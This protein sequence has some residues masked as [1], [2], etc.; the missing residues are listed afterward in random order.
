MDNNVVY[1]SSNFE[2]EEGKE[3]P[4]ESPE[5]Y[6][7]L[8]PQTIQRLQ[9]LLTPEE[10]QGFCRG[11]CLKYLERYAHKDSKLQDAKKAAVYCNWLVES[12]EG[13]KVTV[14]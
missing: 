11:N 10:F 14:S 3:R 9:N 7:R 5:H 12:L 6:A 4:A 1:T 8:T 13:K 2:L